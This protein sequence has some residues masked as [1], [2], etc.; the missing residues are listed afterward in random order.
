[1]SGGSGKICEG[2]PYSHLLEAAAKLAEDARYDAGDKENPELLQ[3]GVLQ[4]DSRTYPQI[5]INLHNISQLELLFV[6]LCGVRP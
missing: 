1:M 6:I 5:I 2:P 3:D 4:I